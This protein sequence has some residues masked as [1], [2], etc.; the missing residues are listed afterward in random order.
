MQPQ[1]A[2][3]YL[4]IL[5][6]AT[7]LLL[8]RCGGAPPP[9][10]YAPLTYAYLKPLRVNVASVEVKD[11][12]APGP[13]DVSGQSPANPAEVLA[14]MAR[15]RIIPAGAGGRAVFTI[16]QA[17][18]L[19]NDTNLNGLLRVHLDIYTSDGNRAAFAEAAVAR[20]APAPDG[21]RAAMRAALYTFTSN[22][23]NDMNVELEYQL[24]RSIGDW[25]E[26]G[27]ATAPPPPPV[28]QQALPPPDA[29]GAT[30]ST[31]LVPATQDQNTLPTPATPQA[32]QVTPGYRL[33][34]S[35]P[36]TDPQ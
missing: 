6:C 14:Q 32:P 9:H 24:R 31:G 15:D 12:F 36:P 20:S 34:P 2:R 25:L 21:G 11:D 23:M 16:Q 13:S 10:L 4:A 8:A 29:T 30:P 7:P 19:D 5:A 28:E 35:P 1:T 3:S 22:M 26:I 17:S 33:V 27:P 18:I